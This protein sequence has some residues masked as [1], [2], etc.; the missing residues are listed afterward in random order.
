MLEN[1]F[2]DKPEQEIKDFL[3]ESNNTVWVQIGKNWDNL[4]ELM[5][6]EYTP[7]GVLLRKYPGGLEGIKSQ[8]DDLI[9]KYNIP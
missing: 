2:P 1:C 7:S 9:R 4:V 8:V 3:I 6:T 5:N